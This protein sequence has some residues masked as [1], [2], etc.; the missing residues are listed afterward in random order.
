MYYYLPRLYV[1]KAVL[2][3]D[4][5]ACLWVSYNAWE[6]SRSPNTF[7]LKNLACALVNILCTWLRQG[8]G[9]FW[10]NSTWTGKQNLQKLTLVWHLTWEGGLQKVSSC[11]K[12]G[13][14]KCTHTKRVHIKITPINDFRIKILISFLHFA[15]T[16]KYLIFWDLDSKSIWKRIC[17]IQLEIAFTI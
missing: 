6:S 15:R 5:T 16:S 4:V 8:R 9:L 3:V 17:I 2:L 13:Y 14:K 1:Y 7:E 10:N 11:P 12:R